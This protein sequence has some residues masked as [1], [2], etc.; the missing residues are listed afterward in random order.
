MNAAIISIGDE[1]MLGQIT[2]T[3]AAWL[4]Q[5]LADC[6][7]FC[8]EH[9]ALGD[10]A[11]R[12]SA[13]ISR[14][15][16]DPSLNLLL[17]T[18]GLGP[19][20]DDITREALA[21]ALK[22]E[23]VED[24]LALQQVKRWFSNT[25]LPMPERNRVQ[26]LRP[27][28][29]EIIENTRGTAPGLHAHLENT[30]IYV[31]PGVP[32][33]MKEMFNSSVLPRLRGKSDVVIRTAAVRCLGLGESSLAEILGSMMNRENNPTVGTTASRGII[34][35][36]ILAQADDEKHAQQLLDNTVA[37]V[38]ERLGIYA[39]GEGDDT[40]QSCLVREL[41]NTG[42]TLAVVESCTG[43][44]IGELLTSVPGSSDVFLGGWITYSNE[45][46]I[47]EVAVPRELFQPAAAG[48]VSEDVARAM[49]EGGREQAQADYA[50][51][52]T[53]IAGPG[54]GTA[55]KPVGTVWIALASRARPTLARHFLFKGGRETIRDRSAKAALAMLLW[56]LRGC[57]DFSMIWKRTNGESV[58]TPDS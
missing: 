41:K 57:D 53:G 40:L 39:F 51:A 23:L 20:E 1:L 14:L 25:S 49:A 9:L 13:A 38:K 6:S 12:L 47:S 4:A 55:E 58:K 44:M 16:C 29:A 22:E 27:T 36:R 7:I 19:T 35:V 11:S 30:E 3:N 32:H 46:K 28:S 26:A 18:G 54:G 33:E 31:L 52:V 24:P 17:I 8:T 21:S 48:A 5:Q 34:T 45:M 15:A 56:K 10:D 50:L 37:E 2:D 43:G 42:S